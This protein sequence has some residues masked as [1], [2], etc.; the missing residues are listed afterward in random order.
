[1]GEWNKM[2]CFFF[3]AQSIKPMFTK[4]RIHIFCTYMLPNSMF[5]RSGIWITHVYI[6]LFTSLSDHPIYAMGW[7]GKAATS[8]LL[9]P[10]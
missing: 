9:M 7:E 1:M 6:M 2:A 4:F 5:Y 8:S 10:I 3:P